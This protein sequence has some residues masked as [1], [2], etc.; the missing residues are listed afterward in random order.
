[1]IYNKTILLIY[2]IEKLG[3]T[4]V[5]RLESKQNFDEEGEDTDEPHYDE[6]FSGGNAINEA[7]VVGKPVSPS[8]SVNTSA[9]VAYN[10]HY[11][12]QNVQEETDQDLIYDT[13]PEQ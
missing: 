8:V 13:I 1:M 7:A 12:R 4:T 3:N 11:Y 6:A 2:R 5:R 9:C 10:K